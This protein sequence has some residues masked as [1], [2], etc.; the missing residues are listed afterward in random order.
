MEMPLQLAP[1][2][3]RH[4]EGRLAENMNTVGQQRGDAGQ[5]GEGA[6]QFGTRRKFGTA[7]SLSALNVQKTGSQVGG[8]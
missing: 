4:V 2:L 1:L 8:R 7:L 5:A 6:R 3:N